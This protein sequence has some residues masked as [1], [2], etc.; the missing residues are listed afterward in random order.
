MEIISIDVSGK[1]AHF[2]KFYANNTALS[3]FIPPRTTIMGMLAAL[4]G[5]EKDSYY[6]SMASD[7]IRI[8]VRV[9]C[10]LKKS[11][12]RLNLLKIKGPSDFRGRSGRVQTPFEIVSGLSMGK[13]DVK[14]RFYISS[15]EG[16]KAIFEELK[17]VL[18]QRNFKYNLSFGTANFSA[19]INQVRIYKEDE[20][21]V[22]QEESDYSIIH[23]AICTEKVEKIGFEKNQKL[24]V[25]EEL[26]P[27]DFIDNNNRELSE[28]HRVIYSI[29][30][31]PIP[32][33]LNGG[34]YKLLQEEGSENITFIE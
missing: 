22:S 5:K 23:S 21:E 33:I 7:K 4:L 19:S 29:T 32:V 31:L 27:A 1:F 28:M 26:I 2:R 24:L 15:F 8:G 34:Y 20:F 10:P 25:E 16:G 30:D 18:I 17:E 11:F 13:D 3:Y 14:Y 6:Q 9:L 12:H